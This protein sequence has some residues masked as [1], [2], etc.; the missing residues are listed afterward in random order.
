MADPLLEEL[1][2]EKA[3]P[4]VVPSPSLEEQQM[5]GL[6]GE[7]A[8]FALG[9]GRAMS[10]GLSDLGLSEAANIVGGES[11][12]KDMLRGLN[13]AKQVNPYTTMAGEF[14]GLLEGGGGLTAL[15]EGV[16]GAVAS[17]LGEG[18]GATVGSMAARGAAEGAAM[19]AGSVISE[20][21]L[22]DTDVAAEK[23]FAHM[24]KDALIGG[25]AGAGF[26]LLAHGAG[27]AFGLLTK[28][29][30]PASGEVLDEVAGVAG[31]GHPY[32]AEAKAL[33]GTVDDL[34][35]AG[36][37]SEQATRLT[38]EVTTMARANAAA[39]GSKVAG[40]LDDQVANYIRQRAGGDPEMAEALSKAY[41][42]RAKGLAS[43]EEGIEKAALT[44]ADKGTRVMRNLEDTAN[45]VQF[46]YKPQQMARLV[47]ASK[48]TAQMDHLAGAMQDVN[49]TLAEL[50][51][52]FTKGGMEVGV[53]KIRKQFQ[54]T[55]RKLLE[56]G[57]DASVAARENA[58]RDLFLIADDLKRA[59]GKQ[60]QFGKEVFV[61][62]EAAREFA[63]L[64]ERLRVGLE[65]AEVWGG[66]GQAQARW[67]KTFSSMFPRRQEFGRRFSVSIDE[68]AGGIPKPEL[69]PSKIKSFLRSLDSEAD[70]KVARETIEQV[71][72][73]NRDRAAAI[74][75]FGDLSPRQL[76]KLEEGLADVT[77]FEQSF[78]AAQKEASVANKLRSMQ[79][80]EKEKAIGGLVGLG[81][82]LVSRPLTSIERFASVRN[83]VDRVEKTINGAFERFFGGAK[84]AAPKL[85]TV[86]PKAETAKI[87]EDLRATSSNPA[88]IGERM[89]RVLGDL[90]DYAP[91]TAASLNAVAM[92]AV[93]YLAAEAPQGRGAVTLGS[94]V[95][96]P[97]FSDQQLAEFQTKVDAVRNPAAVVEQLRT[98]RL[99][100]DGIR[101]VEAVY[102]KLFA[103]M[104]GMA[105]EHIQQQAAKGLLDSMPLERQAAIASLLKVAPN[106]TWRP[107][108]MLLMQGAKAVST[109]PAT[110]QG[111]AATVAKRPVKFNTA[112]FETEAQ[113]IEGRNT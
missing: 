25:A 57:D 112:L 106:E 48:V 95:S 12:R 101:T 96:K 87:I 13:V 94:T 43:H 97:R 59:V 34:R 65:D 32:R 58:S 75:E 42:D 80:E 51:G 100:R 19:G 24:G 45:E 46:T 76:A 60:A 68:A 28:K 88:A 29:P 7:A 83:T 22:G 79:L 16:E 4:A 89:K 5:G 53:N 3:A 8:S 44:M 72:A 54:E 52:T 61:K 98:G 30:G 37:T 36:A 74:K 109:Q 33:Q 27:Q 63:S 17:R 31:G 26:G 91:K 93:T 14:A 67:N 92:R 104:Q 77:A 41:V 90:G 82:D 102:P 56:L 108:F 50:E 66:A 71:I 113:Q 69:D 21:V 39:G 35:A 47:D 107:D 103:Q 86:A 81:A 78:T 99:N 49:T 111:G 55:T 84:E 1:T 70:S 15:G 20:S 40:E 105:R 18:L 11:A 73:G 110:Q 9:A 38:D 85:E 6:L 2:G 10:F 62:P 23:L 64:Y